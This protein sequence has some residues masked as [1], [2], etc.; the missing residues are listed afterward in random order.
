MTPRIALLPEKKFIGKNLMMS[1]SQNRT[2][3]LWRSVMPFRKKI[4]NSL[5]SNL[6]SLQNYPPKFFENF[7][8]TK[9]FQK[10]ALIE[11]PDFEQV[12]LRRASAKVA[13]GTSAATG[14]GYNLSLSRNDLVAN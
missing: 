11:V 2:G 4:K 12:R 8:V 6:V 10:W 5:S 9:Q 14:S 3:E 7:D 13:R 1:F